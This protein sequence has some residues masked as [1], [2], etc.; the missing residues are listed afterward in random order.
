MTAGPVGEVKEFSGEVKII[1]E[2]KEI[3]PVSALKLFDGDEIKTG[4]K[5]YA[6]VI[7]DDDSE[8]RVDESSNLI[9]TKELLMQDTAIEKALYSIK[10]LYGKLISKI[11]KKNEKWLNVGTPTSI[12]GV[13]GT[14]FYS[15]VAPDGST[16]VEVVE[17]EVEVLDEENKRVAEG[18]R[19]EF[20]TEEGLKVESIEKEVNWDEWFEQKRKNFLKR[21]SE[22]A[23]IHNKRM[24]KRMKKL[25]SLIEDI[26]KTADEGESEKMKEEVAVL[27]SLK[28][29]LETG[30]EFLRREGIR[31]KIEKRFK[32]VAQRWAD[33]KHE[34]AQRFEKRRMEIEQRF[35]ERKK[36]IEE[37]FKSRKMKQNNK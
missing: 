8:L 17:G 12:I 4:E 15:G 10:L 33:R 5:S 32:E 18:E 14:E 6:I 28:D 11:Q 16:I 35:K 31:I 34:V 21:K 2:S 20:D 25:E 13:R 9:I 26:E 23:E 1:H 37:R 7:L 30:I 27:Y 22:L 3:P 29:N 24:E 19:A 36:E